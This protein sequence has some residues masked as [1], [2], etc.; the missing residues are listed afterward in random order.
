MFEEL[1]A[2]MKTLREFVVDPDQFESD[3]DGGDDQAAVDPLDLLEQQL[4]RRGLDNM[5][6]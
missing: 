6:S 2:D 1:D 3:S 4:E 5:V